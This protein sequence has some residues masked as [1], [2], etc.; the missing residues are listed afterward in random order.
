MSERYLLRTLKLMKKRVMAV[1]ITAGLGW[2][3]VAAVLLLLGCVWLDLLLDLPAEL[4]AASG[5]GALALAALLLARALWLSLRGSGWRLLARRMDQA[6]CELNIEYHSKRDGERLDS[7]RPVVLPEGQLQQAE[8]QAIE[9][10]MGRTEQYKHT[11]L[12]TDVLAE[13]DS[14]PASGDAD[15]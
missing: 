5:K 7:I 3:L 9:D 1:V 14:P 6:L 13:G 4:R 8:E 10:R 2:A 15:G 11:Y 12:R